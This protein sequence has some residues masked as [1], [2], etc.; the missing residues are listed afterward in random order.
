MS[1]LDMRCDF[2]IADAVHVEEH[3]GVVLDYIAFREQRHTHH[4]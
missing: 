4:R 1:K 3:K 2:H